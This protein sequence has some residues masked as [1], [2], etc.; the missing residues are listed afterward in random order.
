MNFSD[1]KYMEGIEKLLKAD[2]VNIHSTL[3]CFYQLIEEVE[4]DRLDNLIQLMMDDKKLMDYR[5]LSKEECYHLLQNKKID[6]VYKKI[7]LDLAYHCIDSGMPLG[8]SINEFGIN[9]SSWISHSLQEARLC[10]SIASKCGLNSEKAF[11]MGLLHDYGRKY[12]HGSMHI[13]LGFEKLFDLGYY[14]EAIGCLTHSF[15]NGNYFAC[16]APSKNYMVDENLNAIPV[17]EK[18]VNSDLFSFLANYTYSDYDRI[19]NIADLMATDEMV[20]SPEKRILDIEKR[21]KME[22]KQKAFFLF[23]LSST[24]SWYLNKI[25]IT[26]LEVETD[27]I[28]FHNLSNLLYEEV[29][30]K[31]STKVIQKH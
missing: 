5:E 21:R 22:G 4:P 23:Q 15:L 14:E 26:P 7:I 30:S 11:R 20:V 25:G 19:L 1:R 6:E 2:I 28:D 3:D 12:S 24:I 31:K 29:N 18:I 16:Y 13:I 9:K 10:S 8:N 27:I 17:N